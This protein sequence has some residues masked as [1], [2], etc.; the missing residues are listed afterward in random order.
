[1]HAQPGVRST[2]SMHA[3]RAAGVAMPAG[4]PA[5]CMAPC[6]RQACV[7]CGRWR[8]TSR[9][10]GQARR[11]SRRLQQACRRRRRRRRRQRRRRRP[12][13]AAAV[14]VHSLQQSSRWRPA[15]PQRS[16]VLLAMLQVSGGEAT[17]GIVP[18]MMRPNSS[19][20]CSYMSLSAPRDCPLEMLLLCSLLL[21]SPPSSTVAIAHVN[22]LASVFPEPTIPSMPLETPCAACTSNT[23]I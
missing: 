7:P 12:Q 11:S 23:Y 4:R 14:R 20:A 9:K 19:K 13:R 21:I 6:L 2:H 10:A 3:H 5:L 15:M 22:M 1:M 8:P 18:G 16:L 17:A